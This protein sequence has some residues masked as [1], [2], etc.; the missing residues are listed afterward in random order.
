MSLPSSTPVRLPRRRLF[1]IAPGASPARVRRSFRRPFALGLI[2]VLAV[3]GATACDPLPPLPGAAPG[4]TAADCRD[5]PWGSAAKHAVRMSTAEISR[6]RATSNR[7][8]DRMVI[9]LRSAPAAGWHVRYGSVTQPGSGTAVPLRG[10]A[11]LEVIAL[12]PAYG[13]SGSSAFR[14]PN[15]RE[16]VDVSSFRTF[17]QLAF[18]G[19]FEGQSHFGIGV[20]SRLPFRVFAVSGP[21]GHKLVV[22]IAHRW[23]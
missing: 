15:P 5:V 21:S 4:G 10:T 23:P 3:A 18:A 2:A 13:P 20:R 22:D 8:F 11:P 1:G 19:T 17:R 16:L 12:A 9:D 6:V 14:P 7:C